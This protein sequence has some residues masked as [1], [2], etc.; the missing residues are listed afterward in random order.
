MMVRIAVQMAKANLLRMMRDRR[1]LMLLFLM[2][3]VLIA[4]LGSAFGGV[5]G[6]QSIAKF[7]VAVI[8]QDSGQAGQGLASF[9]SGQKSQMTVTRFS[10]VAAAHSAIENG[11]EDVAVIIPAN[12]SAKVAAKQPVQVQ[13]QA[14]L[15]RETDE[16]VTQS[17]VQA[18]GQDFAV[19]AYIQQQS[20]SQ[21]HPLQPVAANIEQ[22]PAGLHPIGAGAYY[23][24][25][26]MAMFMLMNAIN[27]SGNMVEEKGSDLY[28]RLIA[29]PASRYALTVGNWIANFLVLFVQGAVLLLA[30]RWILNIHFGPFAQTALLLGSYSFSLAGISTAVGTFFENPQVVNNLMNIG[31]QVVGVLGGSM[32]PIYNFPHAMQVIAKVLPNGITI[33]AMAD[34]VMG[35]ETNHLLLPMLYLILLGLVLGVISGVRYGRQLT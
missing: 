33:T 8:N 22:K 31:S 6:S 7:N 32:W 28:R 35:V 3:V 27:R 26:M 9:L 17:I 1:A 12:F 21:R 14:P 30:A 5:F 2:P 23:A 15:N 19:T 16:S 34:T 29:A 18:Y 24:I 20:L 13:V 10:T 11:K 4:I 25:G